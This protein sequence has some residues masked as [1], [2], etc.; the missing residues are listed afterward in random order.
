MDGLVS[1]MP[2]VPDQRPSMNLNFDR[3]SYLPSDT[4]KYSVAVHN[5][6]R[7]SLADSGFI[8]FSRRGSPTTSIFF[9]VRSFGRYCCLG[10]VSFPGGEC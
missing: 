7:H 6:F 1:R 5:P 10:M 2:E 4:V 8:G 9:E 3:A